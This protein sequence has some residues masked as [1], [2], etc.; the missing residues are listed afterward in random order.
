[1][2]KII[3][4][5]SV[6]LAW[7]TASSAAEKITREQ[8]DAIVQSYVQSEVTQPGALYANA[9]D[10][11]GSGISITTSNGETLRA[12]YACWAYYLNESEPAQR[13]Y[14]FV[15]EEGGSLLEV[16]ASN[17]LSELSASWAAMPTGLT[18]NKGNNLKQ[19]YPNPVG[20]LLTLPCNGTNARVEICDLKGTRL[21]T[22]LLSGEEP[23]QLNVSFLSAG[24]YMVNVAG[25]TYKIIKN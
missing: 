22:G 3:I 16:I 25:E 6:L 15:K 10:P 19:L 20:D 21:F 8:A 17:D 23:C 18:D 7:T 13:R 1:M 2:K 5:T 14:L 4:L 11:D 9:N 12:K 24:V